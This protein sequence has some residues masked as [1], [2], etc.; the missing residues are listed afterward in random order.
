MIRQLLFSISFILITIN[1]YSQTTPE[2]IETDFWLN[3]SWTFVTKTTWTFNAA[4]LP[5]VGISELVDLSTNELSNISRVTNTYNSN[6]QVVE[7]VIELWNETT[8]IWENETRATFNFTGNN[9]LEAITYNWVNNVWQP[10]TKT[11]S[12]YS[13]NLQ[14]ESISQNWN[15]TNNIWVNATKMEFQYSG[16]GNLVVLTQLNWETNNWVNFQQFNYIYNNSNLLDIIT[17]LNWNTTTVSW[18]NNLKT[19]HFYNAINL[20]T[21]KERENWVNNQWEKLDQDTFIHDANNFLIESVDSDW[22]EVFMAYIPQPRALY[23]RNSEGLATVVVSQSYLFGVGSWLNSSRRRNTY[24]PCATLAINEFIKTDVSIFPSPF[25]EIINLNVA[26]DLLIQKIKVYNLI[27]KLIFESSKNLK[28][29]NL[30][31]LS[32]GIYIL[33][34]T[35]ENKE[36]SFK[37]IKE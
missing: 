29:I 25:Y 28:T 13:N 1:N 26:R 18:E 15:V 5:V 11:I 19:L 36:T 34:L 9:L 2:I 35:I 17:E 27:G 12:N 21:E 31:H 24:P 14:V 22:N 33:K 8:L 7:F 4:C 10:S 16:N 37:I 20:L 32:S 3:N 6:N 30:G 23:T